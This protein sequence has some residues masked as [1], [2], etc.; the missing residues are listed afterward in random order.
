MLAKL[1]PVWWFPIYGY[2]QF[3]FSFWIINDIIGIFID[4]TIQNDI[5]LNVNI[6]VIFIAFIANVIELSF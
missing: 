4:N 1:W 2:S 6:I 5:S 3:F